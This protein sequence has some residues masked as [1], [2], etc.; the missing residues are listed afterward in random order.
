MEI[1]NSIESVLVRAAREAELLG[2]DDVT[3]EHILLAL[4]HDEDHIAGRILKSLG[5]VPAIEEHVKSVMW[6]RVPPQ[7]TTHPLPWSSEVITD[8]AGTPATDANGNIRQ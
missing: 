8:S 3:S 4:A 5:V 2:D 6:E 7:F 1:S